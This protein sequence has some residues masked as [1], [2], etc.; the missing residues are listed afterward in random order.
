MCAAGDLRRESEPE[1]SWEV[2]QDSADF[3]QKIRLNAGAS[4]SGIS[5]IR[6]ALPLPGPA[7]GKN[8]SF[9]QEAYFEITVL[10]CLAGEERESIA[11]GNRKSK[12]GE[13]TKLIPGQSFD[14]TSNRGS[15]V[16]VIDDSK[17]AGRDDGV[18]ALCVGLTAG[19]SLP[20]KL[21]G[22]YP[23]SVGFNTDGSVYL[24]GNKFEL[25]SFLFNSMLLNSIY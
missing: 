14:G 21:P 22:S 25:F 13:R 17:L 1:M 10:Y 18:A 19:G 3:M 7:L 24:D 11:G 4:N 9:P 20:L 23:G 16:R 12:E 6:T 5:V 8:S 15:S 2:C